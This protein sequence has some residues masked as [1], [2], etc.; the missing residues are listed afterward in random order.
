MSL[1]FYLR[2]CFL[3]YSVFADHVSNT[4]DQLGNQ[5]V[6]YLY[7]IQP[8]KLPIW[9]NQKIER[10]LLVVP[11]PSMRGIRIEAHSENR[12]VFLV[13]LLVQVAEPAS[14][15]GSARRAVLGEEIEDDVFL[16]DEVVQANF[17]TVLVARHKAGRGGPGRKHICSSNGSYLQD[18]IC[19]A[20]MPPEAVK[21]L[22]GKIEFCGYDPT[23]RHNGT[24]I[25]RIVLPCNLFGC[26]SVLHDWPPV[27]W[28]MVK[29]RSALWRGFS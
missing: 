20:G 16:P 8:A 19:L 26:E 17:R 6:R 12:N 15:N 1:R 23:D 18:S 29:H 5:E 2:E 4:I 11:E 28:L 24:T 14:L 3:D 27:A 25:L 13:E 9:I 21:R 22:H 7:V 10:E